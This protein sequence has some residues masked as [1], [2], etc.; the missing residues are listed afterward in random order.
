MH[1][2]PYYPYSPYYGL[3]RHYMDIYDDRSGLLDMY[4]EIYRR[5]YP[6]VQEVCRHYDVYTD[7]RMHPRVD[8]AVV[9]EMADRVY[10]MEMSRPY[11]QQIGGRGIFRDLI[12]ILIIRELLGRRR[13]RYRPYY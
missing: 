12:S 1:H 7:P 2:Y 5:I 3:P 11:E 8:P 13:R 9:E 4:P 6:S 10:E